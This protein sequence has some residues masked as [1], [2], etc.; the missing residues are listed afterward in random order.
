MKTNFAILIAGVSAAPTGL[1]RVQALAYIFEVGK[2]NPST[3]GSRPPYVMSPSMGPLDG[4]NSSI[5]L[6]LLFNLDRE[7][8]E[9]T[10]PT[11]C[12]LRPI[13]GSRFPWVVTTTCHRE[14][15]L[16]LQ[17]GNVGAFGTWEYVSTCVQ[18]D[19]SVPMAV[20][21]KQFYVCTT[22]YT[23]YPV[24]APRVTHPSPSVDAINTLRE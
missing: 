12:S 13:H 23:S 14:G 1:L 21:E 7:A 22:M 24:H 3:A 8:P 18:P 6:S 9:R 4:R 11:V 10:H 15:P 16:P 17:Q 19:P 5:H 2:R 20:P